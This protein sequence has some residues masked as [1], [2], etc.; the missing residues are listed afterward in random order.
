MLLAIDIG[1]TQVVT[2]LFQDDKFLHSWRF[3]S[4]VSRTADEC[5]ALLHSLAAAD[6]LDLAQVKG[7]I[8]SSVVPNL[9]LII[10]AMIR[11]RLHHEPIV[12]SARLDLGI[13]IHYDD[14]STVGADRLCNA[15]GGY[16]RYGGPLIIVDF[17]TATTF[18]VVSEEGDYL[19]GII[20]PG[21]ETSLQTLHRRAAR[22]MKV[23]LRFPERLIGRNT[24]TS[25][26]A[27]LMYGSVEMV[28]GL[29]KRISAELGDTPKVILTGGLAPVMV[30]KLPADYRLDAH[31]TLHGMRLI[32]QRVATAH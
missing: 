24:E 5:W 17:G 9:T 2:G 28:Q 3:S 4:S 23:E 21:I 27:G 7:S 29:V 6:G 8:I 11:E 14:P 13:K 31:L 32:Y 12:V 25:M 18:D 20:A 16:A 22:L 10:D 26:Q 15:V 30:P 19:G 1:N